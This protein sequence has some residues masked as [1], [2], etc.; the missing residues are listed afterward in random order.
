M[1]DPTI[2]RLTVR[3]LLGQ[4]RSIVMVLFA[5]LPVLL[6]V[7]YALENDSSDAQEWTA[8]VCLLYTSPSPRD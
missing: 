5:L 4:R 6:A 7:L 1:I 8:K 2:L 3:Q